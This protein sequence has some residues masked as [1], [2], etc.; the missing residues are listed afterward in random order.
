MIKSPYCIATDKVKLNHRI[1]LVH[2]VLSD[3]NSYALWWPQAKFTPLDK[4][5]L[6]VSPKGP[7]FFTWEVIEKSPQKIV[8]KYKGIFEGTG[9]W[10]LEQ[11]GATTHLSYHIELVIKQWLLRFLNRFMPI[12]TLHSKMMPEVF[13]SLDQYLN[14][15]HHPKED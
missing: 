11:K 2:E 5:H 6:K 3:L 10:T 8:L 1:Q 13:M 9:T 12:A 14:N 7:G 4:E 15:F